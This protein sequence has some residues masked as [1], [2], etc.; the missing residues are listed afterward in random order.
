MND[1]YCIRIYKDIR[2]AWLPIRRAI[3]RT[4]IPHNTNHRY[5]HPLIRIV[6]L[7]RFGHNLFYIIAF[8]ACF[9]CCCCCCWNKCQ[10]PLAHSTQ[11]SIHHIIL[12]FRLFTC[13]RCTT[14]IYSLLFCANIQ[15]AKRKCAQWHCNEWECIQ[16]Q[17]Q[18]QMQIEKVTARSLFYLWLKCPFFFLAHHLSSMCC[19]LCTCLLFKRLFKLVSLLKYILFCVH[20]SDEHTPPAQLTNAPHS[21][22]I[23]PLLNRQKQRKKDHDA[24]ANQARDR[25]SVV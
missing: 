6:P 15:I 4:H 18:M 8:V 1:N 7:S 21:P 16:R 24:C 19:C 14:C 25:E 12:S 2:S 17:M 23:R 22:P 9:C 5:A 10:A 13:G 20:M 3:A 11:C